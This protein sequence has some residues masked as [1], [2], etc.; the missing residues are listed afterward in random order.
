MRLWNVNGCDGQYERSSCC[1][2]MQ[3]FPCLASHY[4]IYC[5]KMDI[6]VYKKCFT[7]CYSSGRSDTHLENAIDCVIENLCNNPYL[8]QANRDYL[9]K[10]CLDTN[11]KPPQFTKYSPELHFIPEQLL[12]IIEC[13]LFGSHI[14]SLSKVN[15]S[16]KFLD[17]CFMLDDKYTIHLIVR[18]L[19]QSEQCEERDTLR[20]ALIA[21][22]YIAIQKDHRA[23]ISL[24]SYNHQ[25]LRD[26]SIQIP[27]FGKVIL[28]LFDEIEHTEI[29]E[30][31]WQHEENIE[32][33]NQTISLKN[34]LI[35][36]SQQ[37]IYVDHLNP[38]LL[39]QVTRLS[40]KTNSTAK[41]WKSIL[42]VIAIT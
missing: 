39:S 7:V 4:S 24:A 18:V 29:Y 16:E 2:P 22:L 9:F 25:C 33:R 41:F 26:L 13:R 27:E 21:W 30:E 35:N 6:R 5:E 1:F 32:D 19:E 36:L 11:R 28:K 14:S 38:L 37:I 10:Y 17:S 12:L 34:L 42:N 23:Y 15:E 31:R 40:K 20:S 3:I 8:S